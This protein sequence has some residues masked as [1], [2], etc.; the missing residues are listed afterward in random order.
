MLLT[1]GTATLP[2][3]AGH[4]ATGRY[5]PYWNRGSANG[6]TAL[7]PSQTTKP[8]AG[9]Y[10][11]LPKS[12]G[13]A[14]LLEPYAYQIGGKSVLITT[15][16]V[17]IVIEGRFVG[18][19]GV[20]I[21]LDGIQDMVQAIRIYEMDTPVCCSTSPFTSQPKTA[22]KLASLP[23]PAMGSPTINCNP[24][25]CR[26]WRAECGIVGKRPSDRW[27]CR[28]HPSTATT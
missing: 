16:S 6:S 15:L 22:A 21:T 28:P 10:Y 27:R 12:T 8:G 9:D 26:A 1:N 24:A 25:Y 11:Q 5:V 4:D 17:P 13:K 7:T 18:V 20:D 3:Q 23:T 14:T 2:I 19:A